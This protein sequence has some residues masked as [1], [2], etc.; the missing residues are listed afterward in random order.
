[1]PAMYMHT[2]SG[3][4]TPFKFT[5]PARGHPIRWGFDLEEVLSEE[6][7]LL[8]QH[9]KTCAYHRAETTIRPR[10]GDPPSDS[11]DAQRPSN[12][13]VHS[14]SGESEVD[15][16]E[17]ATM[18]TPDPGV[19]ALPDEEDL[20]AVDSSDSSEQEPYLSDN[21]W[22]FSSSQGTTQTIPLQGQA[23]R[24]RAW[25]IKSIRDFSP[26]DLRPRRQTRGT[27][28]LDKIAPPRYS[29]SRSQVVTAGLKSFDCRGIPPPVTDSKG[30]IVAVVVPSP[31]DAIDW[32]QTVLSATA[33]LD[34]AAGYSDF[35]PMQD[36][37]LKVGVEYGGPRGPRP[38]N[39]RHPLANCIEVGLLL[40]NQAIQEIACFQNTIF[41]SF[42]PKMH[43]YVENASELIFK[44]N[45]DL[46][47]EI[48][49]VF[50]AAEFDLG[51]LGSAPRLED[52]D[53]LHGWRAVTALGTYDSPL[54]RYSFVDVRP[55]EKQYT[56]A[57]YSP[58]GLYRF[59]TNGYVSDETFEAEA[60]KR[61]VERLDRLRARRMEAAL[62]MYSRLD[63]FVN[64]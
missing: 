23:S 57:Q 45:K 20:G 51:D 19:S 13:E 47:Q 50:S 24:S 30:R 15:K 42:A 21:Q 1:M 35:S 29:L 58:A 16:D 63:E 3:N 54:M 5:F 64:T 6:F 56:F 25:E 61:D 2:R 52:K 27:T 11:E 44:F 59:I 32:R 9:E 40:Q 39:V 55:G 43:K 8:K 53:L 12:V 41:Q 60:D 26:Y 28:P 7:Q 17:D 48:E 22:T 49:G 18:A 38:Q 10:P 37:V 46:R 36:P 14:D 4:V 34:R 33:V 62:K 31:T